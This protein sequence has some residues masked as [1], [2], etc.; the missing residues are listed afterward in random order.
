[1]GNYADQSSAFSFGL[2][3]LPINICF[4]ITAFNYVNTRM[5]RKS[6]IVFQIFGQCL[7]YANSCLNPILYAFLSENFRK[8]FRKIFGF[9]WIIFS[10]RTEGA[11]GR[12]NLFLEAATTNWQTTTPPTHAIPRFTTG[13]HGKS[14]LDARLD[15]GSTARLLNRNGTSDWEKGIS[16]DGTRQTAAML[17]ISEIE[18]S[19]DVRSNGDSNAS[20]TAKPH[21]F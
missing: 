2:C 3:W 20:K 6:M 17:Q 4:A 12:Q 11:R 14:D 7:A 21:H 18:L 8:G 10:C 5:P 16:R 1:M 13:E 9:L 19:H 15:C